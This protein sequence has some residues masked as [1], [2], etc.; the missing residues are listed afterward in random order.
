MTQTPYHKA[1]WESKQTQDV[2]SKE[3]PSGANSTTSK[4]GNPA[5]TPSTF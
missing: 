3:L 2:V 1:G 5:L 4:S